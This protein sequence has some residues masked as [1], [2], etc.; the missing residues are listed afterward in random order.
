LYSLA[1]AA[2][3]AAPS[4][5]RA[6]TAS[7][8]AQSLF[9]DGRKLLDAGKIPEACAA[10]ESS[11]K[12]DPAVTT[13]LNLAECRELNHQLATAWG[14]FSDAG[15]MSRDAKDA[16]SQ[17]FAKTAV[18]HAKKLE[19][20]LSKLTITVA[21][22]RQLAGLEITRNDEP[23]AAA[24]WNHA[25]PIDGGTYTIKVSAPGHVAWTVEKTVKV[26]GDDQTIDVPALAD[27]PVVTAPVAA[28]PAPVAAPAA[29]A[30][31][32]RDQ[33]SYVPAIATGGGALVLGGVA[34]GA[35]L[36]GDSKYSDAKKATTQAQQDS[37]VHQA[38]TRRYIAQG[39]GITAAVAA[40]AAVYLFF[41]TRSERQ[42]EV[43]VAP[44]AGP[45]VGG[46]AVVGSW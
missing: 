33:P 30:A 14:L 28:A 3:L 6:Q 15:R 9:D 16:K 32:T 26:E 4:L 35:S 31:Q 1:A 34:L 21:P 18:S 10:F 29:V 5:A 24:S 20:R 12:L 43:A 19:P 39:V 36:A 7:A 23:V 11:E 40:G 22:E 42:A 46:L 45:Q 8:Q 2:T 27:A 25:L 37:L 38:N 17:K 41:H 44:M 13:L